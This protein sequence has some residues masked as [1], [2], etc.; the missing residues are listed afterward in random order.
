MKK[1]SF[2]LSTI[3]LVG[4]L[5]LTLYMVFSKYGFNEIISNLG[6][7]NPLYLV[8]AALILV[9]YFLCQALYMKVIYKSLKENVSIFK[10]YFY[11]IVEFFFSGITPSS[12]GGQPIQLYYMSKDKI[13]VRKSMIVLILNLI[14]FKLFLII[15]GILVL[16]FKPEYVYTN[17]TWIT[18]IFWLGLIYDIIIVF[19]SFMLMYNQKII[20][21]FIRLFFKVYNKFKHR[22]ER[23]LEEKINE[24]L[25]NY[26]EE[27]T[28]IKQ[29]IKSLI[30]GSL[31]T[32]LQRS[33]MFSVAYVIYRGF[34]FSGMHYY[35]FLLL[36]IFF[37]V[38]CEAIMLPSGTGVVEHVINTS[39]ATIFGAS[40]ASA[41]ILN[42]TL[43]CYIPLIVIFIVYVIV[44]R[45]YDK[46]GID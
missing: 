38:T 5:G 1:K 4:L 13:P 26:L 17:G 29:H 18:V 6:K 11:A 45:N 27:S 24:T 39:F 41:M 12:S 2:I 28:Y 19:W 20:K 36:Q 44:K 14:L 23:N 8:I 31:I 33:L 34:G 21:F 37:Q 32:F 40:A 46:K 15:G 16:I 7:M 10:C 42:R 30:F 22:K 25:N 35:E 9:C 43:S 3:F